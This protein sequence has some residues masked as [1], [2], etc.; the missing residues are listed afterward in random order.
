[1]KLLSQ[2]I[3]CSHTFRRVLLQSIVIMGLVSNGAI[4]AGATE[5]T[6][7]LQRAVTA[8]QSNDPWLVR[9]EHAQKS[10]ESMSVAA[11]SLPDPKMNVA[12][13]NFP[14][15]TFDIDQEPMTQ[16]KVSVSQMFPKGDTLA[17]KRK[18][19]EI[20]GSQF[21]FQRQDRKA[22]VVVM[23]SKLWLEAYKAQES[24]T[25]ILKDRPLFEQLGDIA[26]ASY[27]SAMGRTRQQ[28]I[29]RAQ[30]ELTRLDDR[31]TMLRQK[32]EMAIE[33][34]SQWVSSNFRHE[35]VQ[36]DIAGSDMRV[37][38]SQ[39]ELDR[40]L[41]KVPMLQPAIYLAQ[42]TVDPQELFTYFSTHPSVSAIDRKIKASDTGVD[43]ARQSYKPG[44]GVNASYGY[45]AEAQNGSDRADFVSLGVTFDLPFFTENRQDKQV[46]SA[47]SNTQAVKTE[48]WL[49]IREMISKFEN[50][51]TQLVRLEERQRLF[52]RDLLPQ[53]HEQAEASL[54]AYTTDDGDFAEVVR[55]RIAELNAT[56][57]ALGIRVEKQKSIIDLNYFFMKDA[58]QIIAGNGNAGELK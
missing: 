32:K 5:K 39:M 19:L 43:L 53:M 34:L 50:S 33:Q 27:S 35:Y 24:I 48:K 36:E 7:S 56:I 51:R 40:E 17:I 15:D 41:P 47:L 23:V 38:W 55:A 45:R 14:T 57:D 11:G 16:I 10:V 25:L 1:M 20:V 52:E 6:L 18:Q 8:A 12:L 44:W 26:E 37:S 31:L 49:L 58:D 4:L 2:R 42:I 54:T 29:I 13:A 21:P 30:L 22:K 28:D 46:E 3:T 9:S